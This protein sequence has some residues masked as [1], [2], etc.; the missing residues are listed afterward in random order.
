MVVD[1]DRSYNIALTKYLQDHFGSIISITNFQTG[2]HCLDIIDG[3]PEVVILDYFLNSKY[4]DAMNG[5]SILDIIKRKNT[6][7]EIIM[8]SSQDKIGIAVKA[9]EHGAFNYVVKGESAFPQISKSLR[10]IMSTFKLQ[11][12]YRRIRN[13]TL[14]TVAS[15]I[16]IV[17]FTIAV[18]VFHPTLLMP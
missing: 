9:M 3:K 2:E 13:S 11:R 6:K 1:D 4:T 14:A 7:A 8:M 15:I 5:L 16:F 10:N 18:Q 17:A 12:E